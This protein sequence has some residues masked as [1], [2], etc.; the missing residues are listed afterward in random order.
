MILGSSFRRRHLVHGLRIVFVGGCEELRQRHIDRRVGYPK[1]LHANPVTIAA[2]PAFS[3]L[4]LYDSNVLHA[5][6]HVVLDLSSNPIV[7]IFRGQDFD[8]N[9]LGPREDLLD[10]NLAGENTHVRKTNFGDVYAGPLFLFARIPRSFSC[11]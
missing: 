4:W 1:A 7:P 10:R 3:C 5:K 11:K 6:L 2:I 9:Q 8:R